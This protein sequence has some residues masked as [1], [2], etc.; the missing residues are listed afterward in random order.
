[1]GTK[2]STIEING[3]KYDART[4]KL[5]GAPVHAASSPAPSTG[6]MDIAARRQAP[7]QVH[8]A[9]ERSKTLMR[10]AVKKPAASSHS[11]TKSSD[12]S[13]PHKSVITGKEYYHQS[14][15]ER[16]ARAKAIKRSALV[17]KFS[18]FHGAKGGS[19]AVSYHHDEPVPSRI[20]PMAVK[21]APDH[22]LSHHHTPAQSKTHSVLEQGLRAAQSH[23]EPAPAKVKR[24]KLRG[25]RSRLVSVGATSLAVLLLGSFFAY[26][27]IP[28]ASMHYASA[29]A[30]ISAQLPGYRPS[31]FALSHKIEYN[32]GQI[33]LSFR[34]NTDERNFTIT[35]R[36][37][38]WNSDA[39]MA[40]YVAQASGQVQTYQDKGR[41]IYIYGDSNATWVNGGVWYDINGNSQL[42]SDQL[43]RIASSM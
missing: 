43:V 35:Q 18:D 42:N 37:S 20:E 38:T 15:K 23:N 24:S 33:K 25:R 31:G 40:N 1:M 11:K 4:G 27:N 3:K 5:I 14:D 39:L 26:Q 29:R 19:P 32:P 22:A 21:Q 9:V 10:H 8:K 28:Q 17:S 34:S 2:E 13:S 12:I 30:G 6:S 41:T 36:S 16:E 7:K